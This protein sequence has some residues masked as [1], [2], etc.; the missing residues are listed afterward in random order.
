MTKESFK[1]PNDECNTYVCKPSLRARVSSFDVKTAVLD[2][3]PKI[4]IHFP[5]IESKEQIL[6]NKLQFYNT[7][8]AKFLRA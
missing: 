7:P 8:A 2:Y 1:C 3:F 6:I 5:D 4:S